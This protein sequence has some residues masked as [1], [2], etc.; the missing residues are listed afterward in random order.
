[1]LVKG[2]AGFTPLFM[3]TS[4]T[5]PPPT[6]NGM[7]QSQGTT[8]YTQPC[9]TDGWEPEGL[10]AAPNVDNRQ[11]PSRVGT[12]LWSKSAARTTACTWCWSSTC[13]QTPWPLDRQSKRH[14]RTSDGRAVKP[15]T[16][17][18][19][20]VPDWRLLTKFQ[21]Q[22]PWRQHGLLEGGHLFGD[23]CS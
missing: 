3:R 6:A 21:P 11:I 9:K 7:A 2:A 17:T 22:R 19:S 18:I 15:R 14:E 13:E 5:Y 16:Y 23:D 4:D 12:S 8:L 10:P 1:M 20:S